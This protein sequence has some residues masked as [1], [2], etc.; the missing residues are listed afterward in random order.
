MV[1]ETLHKKLTDY[2]MITGIMRHACSEVQKQA[3][4]KR[5]QH[6]LALHP[7]KVGGTDTFG[8]VLF[9]FV[10]PSCSFVVGGNFVSELTVLIFHTKIVS[11]CCQSN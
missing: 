6:H 10:A 11:F 3:K 2:Y 5:K 7:K 1:V 9:L 8:G 4:E